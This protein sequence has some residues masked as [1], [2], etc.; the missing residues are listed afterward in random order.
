MVSQLNR[1]GRLDSIEWLY[2]PSSTGMQ[3][4]QRPF[5]Y[6]WW[7]VDRCYIG[8][9]NKGIADDANAGIL[10]L[11]NVTKTVIGWSPTKLNEYSGGSAQMA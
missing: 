5:G 3:S 4:R 10:C 1:K 6:M 8:C 11:Q 9:L 2:K 7:C